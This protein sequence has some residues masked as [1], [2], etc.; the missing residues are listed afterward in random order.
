MKKLLLSLIIVVCYGAFTSLKAQGK[1][2]VS[3][4]A[5]AT[6]LDTVFIEDENDNIIDTVLIS[7]S[8][9]DAEQENDEID[10]LFDDDLDAGW[11][12]QEGDE[13]VLT[14]GLRFQDVTIPPG[15]TIDSAFIIVFSHEEKLEDDVAKITIYCEDTDDA[16]TFDENNLIS[17]RVSTTA[18]VDWTVNEY[19]GIWKPYSTP[20]LKTIVQEVV[21]RSGW[22][23]GNSIAFIFAG[24]SQG[25]S[26]VENAREMESFEN[27]SDP[28]DEDE[29]GNKG[30]GKNHPDRVPKLV[31]YFDGYKTSTIKNIKSL[32]DFFSV[33]P[34]N[35]T[36]GYLKLTADE[37]LSANQ[38]QIID[39]S[40]RVVQTYS[41]LDQVNNSVL[42]VNR[43]VKGLYFI[44]IRSN[45]NTGVKQF[46]IK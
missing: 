4:I 13:N 28:G 29:L 45:Q 22:S 39:I 30:D 46:I 44:A 8:S 19:W 27:I 26:D 17:D 35:V 14:I 43:L 16:V 23:S 21:D 11:E 3:I 34:V 32:D 2:E 1:V 9:D 31:V 37:S 42:D 33:S 15:A 41:N 7:L 18:T 25:P 6:E 36:N 38:I 20:D 40:G 12:G 24:E 5:T 10:A